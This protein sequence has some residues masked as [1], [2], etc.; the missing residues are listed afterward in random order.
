MFTE[1]FLTDFRLAAEQ[2][3]QLRPQLVAILRHHLRARCIIG[4]TTRPNVGT[5]LATNHVLDLRQG[6]VIL[7]EDRLRHVVAIDGNG[8]A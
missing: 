4:T 5:H 2:V 7:V 3:I 1:F 8:K 6:V